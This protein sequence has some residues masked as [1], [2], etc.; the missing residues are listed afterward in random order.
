MTSIRFDRANALCGA[1]FIGVGLFFAFQ[2]LSLELGTA[3]R[4]GPG[5]FPM[6]LSGLL[7]LLGLLITLRAMKVTELAVPGRRSDTREIVLPSVRKSSLP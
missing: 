5:Y 6:I 7:F 2:S 4:M 1:I 3:L